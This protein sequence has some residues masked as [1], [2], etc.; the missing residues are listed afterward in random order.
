MCCRN[1]TGAARHPPPSALV[2]LELVA[3][4]AELV[5]RRCDVFCSVPPPGSSRVGWTARPR[6]ECTATT[7]EP[8]I[9]GGASR[10]SQA[11]DLE[12]GAVAA[13]AGGWPRCLQ[14]QEV[15]GAAPCRTQ[16][17][18][19]RWR[20]TPPPRAHLHLSGWPRRCGRGAVRNGVDRSSP[21]PGD[22]AA[23]ARARDATRE[24]KPGVGG[25]R[26]RSVTPACVK[27]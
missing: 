8:R 13:R 22:G 9:P 4:L 10:L 15:T 19:G 24:A 17:Q 25:V 16:A 20:A 12:P 21:S 27:Q 14:G 6:Q 5:H 1:G 18:G 7:S 2:L 3:Q 23:S 11:P 26:D